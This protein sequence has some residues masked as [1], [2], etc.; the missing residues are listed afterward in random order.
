MLKS[1]PFALVLAAGAFLGSTSCSA[2]GDPAE[3]NASAD[4]NADLATAREVVGLL[5]GDHGHCNGCHAITATQVRAWGTAMRAV[6]G[7]CLASTKDDPDA[8]DLTPKQRVDCLRSNPKDPSSTF[9]PKRLG[10]YAAGA[11]GADLQGIF[12]DAFPGGAAEWDDFT[13]K[14]AM[15]RAGTPLTADEFAKLKAWVQAGMSGLDEAFGGATK[16]PC[17]PSTT[18]E[19]AAHIASMKTGGWGAR[20][21]DAATPMFGCNASQAGA[22]CLGDR[23]DVTS[24][25]GA[26][27]VT[28]TLRQLHTQP[29]SSHYWVRSS[30][31]GRYVGFGMMDSAKVVDLTKPADAPAIAIEADYDPA[32]LPSND[33][34]AF[35]GAHGNNAITLCK[36]SL[37]SDVATAAAPS[38]SMKESKCTAFTNDVYMSIGAALDGSRYFMTFGDHEND[39][40][41]ND[42][43]Y[44][45]P[46]SFS[47][48]AQ[49]V[50]TPMVNDGL[51]YRAQTPIGVALPNEGDTMLSP[52]SSLAASRFGDGEKALG[53]RVRFVNPTTSGGQLSLDTPLAAEICVPGQKAGFSFDERFLVTHQ[54][55][56]T[57]DPT[58]K[59]LPEGSSNIIVVDLVTGKQT[60]ITTSKS[61]IYALY[62]HFRADGWLYF[63]VRDMNAKVEYLVASDAA[64]RIA[65]D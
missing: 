34:F 37:L 65:Q 55:V 39:D 61:G 22:T 52:S 13:K 16:P 25:F 7:A 31:D 26:D 36:Q 20:L 62:P 14:T 42:V 18:P 43:T 1:L 51:A 56:D 24:M 11:T 45:L 3:A 6:D 21:A 32:F 48:A 53:Y 17:A 47:D 64:L 60:R 19:L 12:H 4:S 57:S 23:P 8:P 50:F 54:Y 35:A 15:P 5:G 28:Q 2:P 27:G 63:A 49:T 58:M 33:G 41:G 38:I 9:S 29:L 59:G 30:A 40:G 10:L 44:P 46:A